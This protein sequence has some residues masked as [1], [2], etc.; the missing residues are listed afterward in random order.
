MRN[1]W[2]AQ[3]LV[4]P[5]ENQL[6]GI[7]SE[8]RL[9]FSNPS[10]SGWLVTFNTKTE[11]MVHKREDLVCCTEL[12]K[13]A[14]NGRIVI[15]YDKL[16]AT[17]YFLQSDT[18][19][20]IKKFVFHEYCPF[21]HLPL[22]M[23]EFVYTLHE[24]GNL[25][26]VGAAKVIIRKT[27]LHGLSLR[28]SCVRLLFPFVS[29]CGRHFAVVHLDV[30]NSNISQ[31]DT[32]CDHV[33]STVG[34][35]REATNASA[36]PAESTGI[37][38]SVVRRT[39]E[40]VHTSTKLLR[41]VGTVPDTRSSPQTM[42]VTQSS[43]FKFMVPSSSVNTS[44]RLKPSA[45]QVNPQVDVSSHVQAAPVPA[46]ALSQQGRTAVSSEL[47]T[48]DQDSNSGVKDAE[49]Q[50][51]TAVKNDICS[52]TTDLKRND[53]ATLGGVNAS[54]RTGCTNPTSVTMS[55][56]SVLPVKAKSLKPF[57]VNSEE[58]NNITRVNRD[59]KSF[60]PF[61]VHDIILKYAKNK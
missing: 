32:F 5:C 41:V 1:R 4:H 30:E 27:G 47:H 36:A 13:L 18:L 42:N 37:D 26:G 35:P 6:I 39:D 15:A 3:V 31:T 45:T 43:D 11:Q 50:R 51:V 46:T 10:V 58:N 34:S 28:Q 2:I 57:D 16:P 14:Q 48:H 17:V 21:L 20:V 9:N 53:V 40:K 61:S 23:P 59:F 38:D 29:N 22:V 54:T 7:A 24:E 52:T 8:E 55:A 49:S 19:D 12:F 56:S 60:N 25:C 33:E 44:L